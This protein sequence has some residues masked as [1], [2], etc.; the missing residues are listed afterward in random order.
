MDISGSFY[1]GN[2]FPRFRLI[3]YG[4]DYRLTEA[5]LRSIIAV[6]RSGPR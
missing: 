4:K 3:S 6:G 5:W 2:T 1:N